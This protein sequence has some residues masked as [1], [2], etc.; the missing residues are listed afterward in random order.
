[1]IERDDNIPSWEV[2]SSELEIISDIRK[3]YGQRTVAAS[4][5]TAF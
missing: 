2:L 4:V 5:A 3:N 1:M